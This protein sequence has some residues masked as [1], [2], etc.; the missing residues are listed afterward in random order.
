MRRH[1]RQLPQNTT[2]EEDN[3][4]PKSARTL[5]RSMATTIST[6]RGQVNSGLNLVT[7]C[8]FKAL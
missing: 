2:E 7:D 8:K 1:A 5:S 6:Q 3:R 4:E